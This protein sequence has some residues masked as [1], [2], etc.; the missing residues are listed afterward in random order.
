MIRFDVSHFHKT[1][2]TEF[3]FRVFQDETNDYPNR[4]M[5]VGYSIDAKLGEQNDIRSLTDVIAPDQR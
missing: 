1:L 2:A 3:S 5:I 4:L